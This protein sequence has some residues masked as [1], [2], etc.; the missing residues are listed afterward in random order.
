MIHFEFF[1]VNLK[2]VNS[3][4]INVHFILVRVILSNR[5][6]PTQPHIDNDLKT[7]IGC[8]DQIFLH[9]SDQHANEVMP[10][11]EAFCNTEFDDDEVEAIVDDW[12]TSFS[13]SLYIIENLKSL[14]HFRLSETKSFSNIVSIAQKVADYRAKEKFKSSLI[15]TQ[16]RSLYTATQELK[17]EIQK[18]KD[19]NQR[20]KGKIHQVITCIFICF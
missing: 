4:S 14:N 16:V 3:I 20:I 11:R 6:M 1:C 2:N 18:V 7:L 5:N 15:M 9:Y 10:F 19:E 17:E 12:I 8:F 13:N